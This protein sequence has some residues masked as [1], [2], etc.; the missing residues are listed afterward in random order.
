MSYAI[1][2]SYVNYKTGESWSRILKKR[3]KTLRGAE[4]AAQAFYRWITMPDG[5]TAT[6]ESHAEIVKVL[7]GIS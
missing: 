1:R 2:Q 5:K 3:W 4:N 6:E 7:D